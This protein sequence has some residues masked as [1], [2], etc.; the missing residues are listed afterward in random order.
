MDVLPTL[1]NQ[2]T[3]RIHTSFNQT[4][5]ETGRLSSSDPNLQNIPAARTG[6]TTQGVHPPQRLDAG[7]RGLLQVELRLLAHFCGEETLAR[8]FAEDR[9]V[10]AAVAA[11][12]F[13]VKEDD[14]TKPQRAMAKT[15][16]FGVLY[17]MSAA[18]LS[19]RLSIPRKEA[20]EFIDQYFAVSEGPR[21]PATT[22]RQRPRQ[23]EVGTLLGRKRT[24]NRNAIN[25]R[26][27][28]K[29]RGQAEREAINMEI[30]GSAADLM[31]KAMLA[32]HARL[33]AEKRVQDPVDG[34]RRTGLRSAARR[35][36]PRWPGSRA[37]K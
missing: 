7:H 12:I 3:D 30:Q 13:K 10:H 35:R 15:V 6:G 16:N 14:V 20:E 28:Y 22:A 8:A 18:G 37:R 29:M 24:F 19:T 9:D 23:G 27:H 34:A 32:V 31:K 25:P 33:A 1:V 5:A 21:L 4:A 26:S 36:W 11:Q 2:K 17:G